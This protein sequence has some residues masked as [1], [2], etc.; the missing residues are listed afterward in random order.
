MEVRKHGNTIHFK[1]AG[2]TTRLVR[3]VTTKVFQE[4]NLRK[5]QNKS[6]QILI[7]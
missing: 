3:V 4:W 6:Y 1:L 5:Q 2:A 7:E